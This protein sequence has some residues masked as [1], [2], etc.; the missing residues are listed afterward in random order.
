MPAAI[1][2][3]AIMAAASTAASVGVSIY[4]GKKQDAAMKASA[5][6]AIQQEKLQTEATKRANQKKPN[7]NAIMEA[8][9]QATKGGI[10]GTMLTGPAGVTPNNAMLGKTSLLGA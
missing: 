5:A 7:V 3:P 9:M 10:S 1:L 2:V 8:A 4:Q 6:N